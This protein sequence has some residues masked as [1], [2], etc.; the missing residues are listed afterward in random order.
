MG[1]EIEDITAKNLQFENFNKEF[2]ALISHISEDENLERYRTE[3]KKL[4]RAF[5][6][7]FDN[8]KKL[9]KKCRELNEMIINESERVKTAFEISQEDSNAIKQLSEEIKNA[10]QFVEKA[11]EREDQSKKMVQE[12][13]EEIS[14]L[15]T[16]VGQGATLSLG[17][18]NNVDELLKTKENL[19]KQNEEKVANITSLEQQIIDLRND[20]EEKKK[21]ILAITSE[22]K[23]VKED[24]ER[25]E[26]D[27]K[28]KDDKIK[29]QEDQQANI[30]KDSIC[31]DQ[32]KD[33][34]ERQFQ[35]TIVE[36]KTI[37]DSIQK[38]TS[39]LEAN[40]NCWKTLNANCTS[41]KNSIDKCKN[42][43]EEYKTQTRDAKS[44]IDRLKGEI[45]ITE[46][47][48]KKWEKKLDKLRFEIKKM[49]DKIKTYTVEKEIILS[50]SQVLER[51]LDRVQK[52]MESDRQLYRNLRE[53]NE[54]VNM[55]TS[56]AEKKDE[57]FKE[58]LKNKESEITNWKLELEKKKMDFNRLYK[59]KAIEERDKEKIFSQVSKMQR[60]VQQL[61]EE[62]KLKDNRHTEIE[63]KMM[64]Y[65]EKAKEKEQLYEVVRS[66]RNLYSKSLIEKH[67]EMN[68]LKRKFDITTQQI[69]QLKEEL[70]AKDK[71]LVSKIH[72][73]EQ[74]KQEMEK[75]AIQAQAQEA[76]VEQLKKSAKEKDT[77]ITKLT[78]MLKDGENKIKTLQKSYEKA[79]REKDV[80]GTELIRRNDE[81][82]LLCEKIKIL[83][84]TLA[85]A[86]IQ[87]N[88][89]ESELR[90]LNTKIADNKGRLRVIGKQAGNVKD[91][92]KKIYMLT[93]ELLQERMQVQALSEELE[94]PI[95]IH[96]WR[97]LE[98]T[99]PDTYE[100]LQ[101]IQVLQKRLIKKTEEVVDR[102]GRLQEKGSQI[103]QLEQ[104]LTRQS[105]FNVTDS[106]NSYQ[107]QLKERTKQ[108]KAKAAEL[109]MYQAQ[110]T[111]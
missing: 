12:L 18:E 97:K 101:K 69:N 84:T 78:A 65:K 32:E 59:E 89:K 53:D 94:N 75:K 52:Q 72:E 71:A 80:F 81:L 110:V 99:D 100:M 25:Y 39:D 98:G 107:E 67:D 90:L 106:I 43:I 36:C 102:E 31:K 77:N 30:K 83:Q 85:N 14:H 34:L 2:K 87:F 1:K 92:K 95:N 49:N 22:L 61:Q 33:T 17:P 27:N 103:D 55:K 64:E 56:S 79:I 108:L 57:T 5:C 6:D 24:S 109:N 37:N 50:T 41:L 4:Y 93:N 8:E 7:S 58:D 62:C 42:E 19:M 28:R 63:R 15:N 104:M 96:R 88:D 51:D 23:T 40:A 60:K 45:S 16:I 10:M 86:E 54:T 26:T 68:E 13:K 66:D 82:T 73:F 20:K 76:I 38:K 48:K 35:Q 70:E 21:K 111:L 3:Y 91:L 47:E 44:E 11:R 74:E 9:V 29:H 105:G 46:G